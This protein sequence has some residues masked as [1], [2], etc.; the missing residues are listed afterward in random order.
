MIK[1][2]LLDLPALP[3]GVQQR[4]HRVAA[5]PEDLLHAARLQKS[6]QLKSD[7]IRLHLIPPERLGWSPVPLW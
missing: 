1:W 3:E 6:N 5:E 7:Q 4:D 2:V